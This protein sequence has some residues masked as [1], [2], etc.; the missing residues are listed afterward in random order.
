MEVYIMDTFFTQLNCNRCGIT[1]KKG[2][3]MSM[4][5]TDCICLDCSREEK[6]IKTI[7]KQLKQT[8]LK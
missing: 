4:F 6:N 3:I 8:K 1:L 7:I 5:N 2:R